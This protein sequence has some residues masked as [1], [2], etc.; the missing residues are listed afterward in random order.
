MIIKNDKIILNI[1]SI[2]FSWIPKFL[3]LI[4]TFLI[5]SSVFGAELSAPTIDINPDIYYP[6]DEVLYIEGRA[7]PNTAI[8]VQFQKSGAKPLRLVTK[9]DQ[10]GEWVLAEKAPLEAGNWE[11][12][13]R[14]IKGDKVSRWSNPRI[15]RA[16]ASGITLGGL[17]IKF[18]FLFI[19]LVFGAFLILYLYFRLR[20]EHNE[21]TAALIEQDFSELRRNVADELKHLERQGAL[22]NEEREHRDKLLRDLERMER[23]IERRLK[24]LS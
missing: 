1:R 6:L 15:I 18:S 24:D 16:I 3:I 4:P 13:V 7:E 23:E 11:I 9:S 12:R 10:N 21:K 8:Q 17:T 20:R 19:V 2:L 22:S 5:L 14:A